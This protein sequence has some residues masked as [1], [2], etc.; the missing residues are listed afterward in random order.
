[1]LLVFKNFIQ[2]G[3]AIIIGFYYKSNNIYTETTRSPGLPAC[4]AGFGITDT[5]EN[6]T[7][8]IMNK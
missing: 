2:E 4:E 1:M 5:E 6:I 3:I 8:K 7:R